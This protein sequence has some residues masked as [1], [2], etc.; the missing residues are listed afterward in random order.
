MSFRHRI[1]RRDF[2]NGAAMSLAAGTS[3]S[4]LDIM[5][6]DN[7]RVSMGPY[8]PALTSMRGSYPGSFERAVNEQIS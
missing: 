6:M 4:P 7:K 3:L 5:A 2:M 8:P 1:S